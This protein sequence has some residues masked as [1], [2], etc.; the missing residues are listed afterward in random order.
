MRRIFLMTWMLVLFL[1]PTFVFG[2]NVGP[3]E[4]ITKF[5]Q[6]ESEFR[7]LWEK[8]TYTQKVEFQVLGRSG[9]VKERRMMEI[10]VYFTTE[11]KRQTRVLYDRGEL[12]SLQVTKEDIG[13][14]VGLQP[15][16]LTTEQ[17]PEYDIKYEGEERV[18]ELDTYVF[19]VEPKKIDKKKRYFQGRLWVDKVDFQ[20]VMTRGKAVPDLGSNKFPAF[21][22]VREQ[23][24]GV[25]WFPT[26]TKADD[27]L[28]F[29]RGNQH[30][31][32]MFITYENFKKFE[33]GT[34]IKYG[35]VEGEPEPK[36]EEKKP[37]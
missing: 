20:I 30:H 13:D 5:A 35:K 21:E 3:Q 31:V 26:W 25:Y 7:N 15:F 32:R 9:A 1:P 27:V 23:I 17:L 34:S 29:G 18:D 28:D 37:E 19:E 11:G 2:Q 33:V 14:A 24:D 16:V 10:E 4:I 22:T 12:R 8:Y 6:K 36:Q